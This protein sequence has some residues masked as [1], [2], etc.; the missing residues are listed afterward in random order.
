MIK[1]AQLKE[2]DT[3]LVILPAAKIQ[4]NI[5]SIVEYLVKKEKNSV[6]FIC[7]NKPYATLE[8]NWEKRK[9]DTSQILF[10]DCITASVEKPKK[11]KN[12]VFIPSPSGLTA[13]SLAINTFLKGAKGK[14][15]VIIDALS[16]LLI[17][18]EINSVAR[19]TNDLIEK[20]RVSGA[21][22]VIFTTKHDELINKVSL[23]F[24]R[25]IK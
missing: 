11:E 1:P 20:A 5:D 13:I 22:E 17:Y 16:T 6:A 24:D 3:F 25:I 19:F 8:K 15:T 14:K 2:G 10:I 23:F 7:L 9:I 18:N 21:K 12:V 4:P